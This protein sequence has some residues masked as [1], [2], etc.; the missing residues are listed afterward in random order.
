MANMTRSIL[1]LAFVSSLFMAYTE[2]CCICVT[3]PCNCTPKCGSFPLGNKKHFFSRSGSRSS[4][5]LNTL[6]ARS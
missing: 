3:E 6:N 2:A 5:L 4:S 1:L